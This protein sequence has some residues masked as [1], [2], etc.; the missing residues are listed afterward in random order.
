MVLLGTAAVRAGGAALPRGFWAAVRVWLEKPQVANRRLCG[1]AIE[2]EGA[3]FFGED[4]DTSPHLGSGEEPAGAVELGRL[5]RELRGELLPFLA[6]GPGRELRAVL[7]V[8][9]PRARPA[10][11]LALPVKELVVQG[12]SFSRF[13]SVVGAAPALSGDRTRG[14]GCK[15]KR[16]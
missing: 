2:A 5:W 4:G 7:R 1:A 16:R 9:L 10:G 8:L 11:L 14:N 3:V 6:A 13:C 12:D 15:L